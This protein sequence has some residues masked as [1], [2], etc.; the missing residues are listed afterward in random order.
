[1]DGFTTIIKDLVLGVPPFAAG[2]LLYEKSPILSVSLLIFG[3]IIMVF[4]LNNYLEREKMLRST[5]G[6]GYLR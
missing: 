3:G 4:L 2:V 5:Y 6:Y 1:M